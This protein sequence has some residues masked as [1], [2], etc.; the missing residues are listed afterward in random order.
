[1]A[2]KI[3]DDIHQPIIGI[4]HSI[5]TVNSKHGGIAYRTNVLCQDNKDRVLWIDPKMDNFAEWQ[6]YIT[7]MEHPDYR[8]KC[9][10]VDNLKILKKNKNRLNADCKPELMEDIDYQDY[11]IIKAGLEDDYE[12]KEELFYE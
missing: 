10:V 5:Q 7:V 4:I 2:N 6:D 9:L 1:M 3:D 12:K 8:D 11:R